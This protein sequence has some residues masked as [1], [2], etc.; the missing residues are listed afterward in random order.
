MSSPHSNL[1]ESSK[2]KKAIDSANSATEKWKKNIFDIEKSMNNIFK[3]WKEMNTGG[4]SMGGSSGGSKFSSDLSGS[5]DKMQNHL[6]KMFDPQMSTGRKWG[7]RALSVLGNVAAF[8]YGMLPNTMEAVGQRVQAQGVASMA[9]MDA[10]GLIKSS[11]AMLGG[12]FTSS[13]SAIG[14][15]TML[16]SGGILPTTGSY[17]NLMGQVGG[18]SMLT[19][20]SNEQVASGM[21]SINGNNFMR[22]GIRARDAKGNLRATS[23][24][25]NDLYRRMY[26]NRKD[27]KAENAAQVYNVNS[28][29]YQSVM[30]VAG[31][32]QELF[33]TLAGNLVYQA[34]NKGKKLDMSA[35]NVQDN[36]LK[37]PGDDPMRKWYN[38]QK[39]EAGK[40]EVSGKGLV[41]GYGGAL[42]ATAAVNE[43]FTALAK[44]LP[45]IVD[46]MGRL[47]GF[48]GTLPQ[49]GNTGSTMAGLGS[50]IASNIGA[51]IKSKLENKASDWAISKVENMLGMGE[52]G[53][54]HAGGKMNIFKDIF[55]KSGGGRHAA[56]L[57]P[58]AYV[59][60]SVGRY[61]EGMVSN[62]AASEGA[63]ASRF[64]GLRTLAGGTVAR[65]SFGATAAIATNWAVPKLRN[66]GRNALGV[67]AGSGVDKAGSMAAYAGG[68]AASGA[69]IGS[70]VPGVGT[71]AG[72]VIGAGI[73]LWKGW[74]ENKKHEH[75][76]DPN[77]GG[78]AQEHVLASAIRQAGFG[79]KASPI[80]FAVAM[81]ES[82]GGNPKA[83]NPD[84][85]TGDNSYG[86]FQINM[87][88]DIGVN[89]RK[90]FHLK[91]NEQLFNPVLNAKIAYQISN[92][93]RDWSAWTTYTKGTY[94]Q[95]LGKAASMFG[96][97]G[98]SGGRGVSSGTRS[99]VRAQHGGV[100]GGIVAPADGPITAQY[101]QKP[102]NNTYWQMKGYHTGTDYGV[103]KG[104]PVKAFRAGVVAYVGPG[105]HYAGAGEA[106]GNI[107]VVDHGGY[108]S[109]YAHLERGMVKKG[110]RVSAGQQIALS[111]QS[112]SGAKAGPHLHFEI[113]KGAFSAINTQNPKGYL[114]GLVGGGSSG[115]GTAG[116]GDSGGQSIFQ[117]F[118]SILGKAALAVSPIGFAGAKFGQ[119]LFGKATGD[120]SVGDNPFSYVGNSIQSTIGGSINRSGFVGNKDT[121]TNSLFSF[122][123]DTGMMPT[124]NIGSNTGGGI[125]INMNVVVHGTSTNDA[126]KF[127]N[128][129]KSMLEKDLRTAKIGSY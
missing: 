19:G 102:K 56:S 116:T 26:G 51:D 68:Y 58:A 96:T 18:Y 91:N 115:S 20:Q 95:Y 122:G 24:I 61:G 34:K 10:Q 89:R 98:D 43:Q 63:A 125:V 66:I 27:V 78:D 85:S 77:T 46:N 124:P 52:S 48:L 83:H 97:S 59:K 111:G 21:A 7:G 93:G 118:G 114:A 92:K 108:E 33:N 71:A 25:A 128:D 40:L 75:D 39:S 67:K 107:V 16:A 105:Q 11:N 65:L 1:G 55:G 4:N 15:T 104:S 123:G 62:A 79:P 110:Q 73:G 100:G 74:S 47:K 112:G 5:I 127:A 70:V 38:Y 9:G 120:A 3:Q 45:G 103:K 87:I 84:R 23:D 49:A 72:A 53:G 86:L 117:K 129:V 50:N 119:W 30:A 121:S 80:A 13:T 35:K 14:A 6:D 32:N 94:K 64:A 28:K 88:D 17:K 12:G 81:A 42:D 90:Q 36:I 82:G 109:M 41:Q 69:L 60:P 44:V 29:A 76:Q 54:T 31:G 106:Y 37:L 57:D 101:G 126:R 8:G 22:V 99:S 2:S 113:R